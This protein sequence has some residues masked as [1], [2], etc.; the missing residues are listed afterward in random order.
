MDYDKTIFLFFKDSENYFAKLEAIKNEIEEKYFKNYLEM[1]KKVSDVN[2]KIGNETERVN[3]N[4]VETDFKLLID[5]LYRI[6]NLN[7]SVDEKNKKFIIS[8]NNDIKYDLTELSSGQK[9]LLVI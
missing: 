4:F 1:M 5:E 3:I 7:I 9:K 2:E 6:T 8:E